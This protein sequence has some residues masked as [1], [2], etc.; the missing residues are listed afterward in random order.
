MIDALVFENVF[1]GYNSNFILSN[2][3]FRIKEGEFVTV[4]GPNG[5]GKTTLIKL[6]I[7]IL[8]P[9]LGTIRV[10][11]KKP[12][13]LNGIFG[14]VPQA[15]NFD[16][17]FPI[18]VEETV[19]GGLVKPFGFVSNKDINKVYE[20]LD[21]LGI[22]EYRNEHLFSLSGGQQQRVLLARALVSSPSILILDEPSSNID[23]E[24]EEIIGETLKKLKG[25][26]TI[27]VIT[28]DTGFV[29]N[30]TDKTLCV[31][32][33]R[34]VEHHISPEEA[35]ATMFGHRKE[36]KMVVHKNTV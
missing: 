5:S 22:L 11:G 19:L 32:N 6:L 7:G 34:V 14:Y 17:Q 28:H 25:T 20:L 13:E 18:T 1:F 35:L 15:S 23:H 10:Y 3:S 30:L 2:V 8:K 27:I 33:G 9:N 36:D 16:I 31:N 26:K 21:T 12:K 4:V 29:N 24:G